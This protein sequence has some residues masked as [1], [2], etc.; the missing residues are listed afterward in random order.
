MPE[1]VSI[2]QFYHLTERA[3]PLTSELSLFLMKVFALLLPILLPLLHLGSV[4]GPNPDE[5]L[6][7]R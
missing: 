3:S 4:L 5:P 1:N 2:I 7:N 6:K